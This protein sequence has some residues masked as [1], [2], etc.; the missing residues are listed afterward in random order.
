MPSFQR[1]RVSSSDAFQFTQ[2]GSHN[3]AIVFPG[4]SSFQ[5]RKL[6][7]RRGEFANGTALQ[8]EPRFARN[9]SETLQGQR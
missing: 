7:F 1:R 3:L 4:G 5:F 6:I 8:A 9:G 2:M